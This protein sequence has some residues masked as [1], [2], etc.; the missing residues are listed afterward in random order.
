L[1]LWVVNFVSWDIASAFS[2][3][4]G[5]NCRLGVTRRYLKSGS[6]S[7]PHWAGHKLKL[8]CVSCLSSLRSQQK[9]CKH[10]VWRNTEGRMKSKSRI[11]YRKRQA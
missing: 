4:L 1:V 3:W 11:C 10:Q 9:I 7:C 8:M 6:L 2:T 5:Y